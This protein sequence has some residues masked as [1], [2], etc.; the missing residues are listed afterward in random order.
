MMPV[1]MELRWMAGVERHAAS[2][3]T[4]RE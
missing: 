2:P 1:A 3:D 4:E